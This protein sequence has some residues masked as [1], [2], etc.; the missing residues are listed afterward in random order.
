MVNIVLIGFMGSG[1]TSVGKKIAK[2]LKRKFYDC[3]ELIA[4]KMELSIED[5]FKK[6]GEIRFRSIE[7]E[8]LTRLA[9]LNDIVVATGGGAITR[10]RNVELIKK[11]GV[12]I[13]LYTDL[14]ELY[15]RIKKDKTKRPLLE[16]GEGDFFNNLAR[17]VSQREE[18]YAKIADIK[19]DTTNKSV[20]EVSKEIIKKLKNERYI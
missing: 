11:N 6:Y 12:V 14:L 1:K 15:E 16:I 5:I 9:S 7:T 17:L 19:I 20:E 4:Q 8:V 18:L 2:D 13:Y 10:Y 3:D